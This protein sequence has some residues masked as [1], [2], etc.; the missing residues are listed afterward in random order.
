MSAPSATKDVG[1]QRNKPRRL[2]LFMPLAAF[3]AL[4]AVFVWGLGRDPN[5]IPSQLIGKPV[6]EFT[7]PPVQGR[8]LG[9]SSADLKGEV[10][11]VNVFASWCVACR[12]EHPLLMRLKENGIV[13]VHGINYKD[14]PQDAARWLG[15]L[16]DPYTRTGADIDGRVAIDWGVYGV[17][18]T[19]VVDSDGTIVYKQIGPI[20]KAAL[21]ETILPL[22]ARLQAE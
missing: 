4:T 18:E 21:K 17:P 11:L 22:V 9:L 15:A 12:D 19:F 7:L 5:Q 14:R 8:M 13:P 20:T 10:S 2:V 3:M 16:G 1:K 6:P